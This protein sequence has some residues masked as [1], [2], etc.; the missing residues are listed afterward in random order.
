MF[1]LAEYKRSS[2]PIASI[3]SSAPI[4]SIV[5]TIRP[6]LPAYVPPPANVPPPPPAYVP[7]PND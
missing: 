2:V 7:P 1:S 4:A 3:A 5:P 6:S